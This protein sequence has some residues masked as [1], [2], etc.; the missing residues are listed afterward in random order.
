M[1]VY[2]A[3]L[4]EQGGD[5]SKFNK[6]VGTNFKK[7]AKGSWA[8]NLEK[9]PIERVMLVCQYENGVDITYSNP[10][11]FGHP[12]TM[13]L[14]DLHSMNA[15]SRAKM[16]LQSGLIDANFCPLCSFW[17]T[18]NEM[19]N[20]HIRKHY[21]M[22]LTCHA[23]GFMMASVATMKAHME[24]EHGYKGKHGRQAKKAKGKG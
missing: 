6:E 23:D 8:P 4:K 11:G 13:G 15:L 24:A 9:V 19:L 10:D 3:T 17:N 5:T 21:R 14:W 20:N 16:L 12:G 1:V 18:N 2:H 22:G 7:G